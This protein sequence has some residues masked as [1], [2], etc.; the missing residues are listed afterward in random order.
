MSESYDP[1]YFAPLFAAEDKHFWFQVRNR[2]I[3]EV[4]RQITRGLDPGYRVLEVGCGTGNVLRVLEGVCAKGSVTGMDLFP[5]GLR[6]AQQRTGC[7][8]VVGDMLT[9]PF[10][11]GRFALI[12]LFDVLEHL[13][14]DDKVLRYLSKMLADGGSLLLT[15]PAYPQLW[16]YFDEAAHHCRRYRPAEIEERLVRAGYRLEYVTPYM[17]SLFPLL[18]VQRRMA[19]GSGSR[20]QEN[21]REM[22]ARD[23][24]VPPGNDLLGWWLAREI[25]LIRRR[26]R[27]PFGTSLLAVA[28]KG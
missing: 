18:W 17:A 12:G 15:V 19:S 8:L 28:R 3:A 7:A 11:D 2:V 6:Y 10:N 13:R 14:D 16:S 1:H 20:S 21:L 24:T 23:L 27:L 22:V 4:V 9:P 25:P 5:E 26:W